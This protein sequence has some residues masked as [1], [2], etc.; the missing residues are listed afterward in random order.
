MV[1]PTAL[2]A[3]TYTHVV[4]AALPASALARAPGRLALIPTYLLVIAAATFAIATGLGGWPVAAALV[5]VNGVAFAGLTFIGHELLHGSIAGGR[6]T[7][8]VLGWITFL[9]FTMSPRLWEAWHNQIH[10][11]HTNVD[12]QD[13]D[14]YP[15]LATYRANPSVR[16]FMDWFALG[17][18]RWRGLLSLAFG[19]TG[20]SVQILLSSRR[21]GF[22]PARAHRLALAETALGVALWTT[23]AL[24]VG[25][26]AFVLVFVL[27]LIIANT[28]VMA[29]ILTNHGLSPLAERNDPLLA[30]LSV[31][32]PRWV[33][34]LTLGFGYHVEHHVLPGVSSRHAR[35]VRAVL[36]AHWP[37]RYQALPHLQALVRLHRTARVYRDATTLIDPRTGATFPTLL[38]GVVT[39]P[40]PGPSVSASRTAPATLP[41]VM[42]AP[43]R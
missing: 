30:S 28:I 32:G 13:P 27:P 5:V 22:L 15:T 34:L 26:G 2:P 29:F 11:A 35:A 7:R 43:A 41:V 23:L 40:A 31:T 20:Q 21:R 38:P 18:G 16:R 1:A 14:Q 37:E 17:G 39:A 9:P 36:Q 42:P 4:R 25:G 10:H 33:E 8:R 3:S 12:G 19:F 6:R 24:V